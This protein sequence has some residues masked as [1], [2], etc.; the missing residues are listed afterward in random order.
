MFVTHVPFVDTGLQAL[1]ADREANRLSERDEDG[2]TVFDGED[3][4]DQAS[5]NIGL[6]GI[7]PCIGILFR[8]EVPVNGGE[9]VYRPLQLQAGDSALQTQVENPVHHRHGLH[10]RHT[11]RSVEIDIHG[12][13]PGFSQRVFQLNRTWRTP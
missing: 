7:F 5:E 6:I 3:H 12:D 2:W 11:A 1:T 4:G 13:R 9:T 8:T 10:F